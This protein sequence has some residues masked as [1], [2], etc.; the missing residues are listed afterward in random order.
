MKNRGTTN[1]NQILHSQKLKEKRKKEGTSIKQKKNHQ[2]EK[3]K[4]Q[5]RNIESTG[6]QN[7]KWQFKFIY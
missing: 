2:P 5:R 3:R 4:E 6:K 7:L 1:Q